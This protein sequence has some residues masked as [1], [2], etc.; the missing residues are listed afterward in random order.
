MGNGRVTSVNLSVVPLIDIKEH[1][2]GYMLIFEDISREKRVKTTMARYMTK[3]VLDKLVE[4][5]DSML[6]GTTQEV[7][8]LFSDIR[9]FTTLSEQLGARETVSMLNEYF[10]EMIDVIFE[11][12]GILD[13]YIGDA[14]MALFGTPFKTDRDVDN[15][16]T[17]ANQMILSLR[18]LNLIRENQGKTPIRIGVGIST[19]E[20][21][22]GN[23]GSPKRMDYT[24]IGDSVNIASRLEGANKFYGTQI[25]LSEF[26]ASRLRQPGRLREIDLIRVK[27]KNEPVAIYESLDCQ[28]PECFPFMDQALPFFQ[29]GLDRYRRRDWSGAMD[30]F[31]R[32][33]DWH[34][35][36][37]PSAL[38]LDRCR[39]YLEDP[40]DDSW[41]G[42]WTMKEK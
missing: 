28:G 19:G 38:Y 34:P 26:T 39:H 20:V 23:I 3:E 16:V 36:D 13:K 14:I 12:G 29:K 25:L 31:S 10:S 4:E 6:G 30:C 1:P 8:V 2:I 9:S 27:G 17:V 15:A 24:V 22:T 32:I 35:G 11:H 42:V 7:T 40:P 33:L 37:R 5:G 18:A 41:D 21:V